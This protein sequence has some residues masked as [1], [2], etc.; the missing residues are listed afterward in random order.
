MSSFEGILE[1][2]KNSER[3]KRRKKDFLVIMAEGSHLYPFRTQK[4]SPPAP[5]VLRILFVGE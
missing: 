3:E 2:E 5:M 1:E 4:L